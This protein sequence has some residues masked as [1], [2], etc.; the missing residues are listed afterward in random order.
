MM[1]SVEASLKRLQTD[2][3]DLQGFTSGIRSAL[4]EVMRGL[5][6]LV[7]QRKVHSSFRQGP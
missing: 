2:Y 7:R 3:V 5:D 6:D 1:Q 4:E